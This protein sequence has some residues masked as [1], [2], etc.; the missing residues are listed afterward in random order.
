MDTTGNFFT[1]VVG[2][3]EPFLKFDAT[4]GELTGRFSD[5]DIT[6]DTFAHVMSKTKALMRSHVST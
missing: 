6:A 5:V 1:G 4:A 2:A 3:D